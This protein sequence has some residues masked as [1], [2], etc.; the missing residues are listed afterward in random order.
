MENEIRLPQMRRDY[1]IQGWVLLIY[2]GIMS[3][4]VTLVMIV[5][6]VFLGVKAVIM[7][8]IPEIDLLIDQIMAIGGWGYLLAIVVGAGI[9]LLWKKPQFCFHTIWEKK[10]PMKAGEFF[11]L[12]SVFL[13]GQL[14]F[15]L[16][17]TLLN[18]FLNCF[19][20]SMMDITEMMDTDSLG[21]FLYAG[22]GAPIWEEILFRGL[23]LRSMQK[24]GKKFA[25]F[26]SA[27]MFG[28]FHGNLSQT[29]FA[30]AVGLVLGYVAVEYNL[31]WSIVLHMINNLVLSDLLPRLT[32]YLPAPFGDGVIWAIIIA[33][34]IAAVIILIVK[35]KEVGAYLREE[36]TDPQ[37]AKAFFT[38]PGIIVMMAVMG[39]N[40]VTTFI[41]MLL[42]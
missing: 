4:L 39:L 2:Y 35:R 12:L 38:A 29:P 9:L 19:G 25:I 16:L 8:S 13:S 28:L 40:I 3:E 7:N 34:S 30:F 6:G 22:I 32:S 42:M 31:I 36:R 5:G 41:M 15:A 20:L 11:A 33:F 17:D 26:G 10:K 14:I 18:A 1:N 21:M 37:C 24:H 27:L 23:I